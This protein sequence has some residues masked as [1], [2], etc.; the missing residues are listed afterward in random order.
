MTS[1]F[2]A[3]MSVNKH[4]TTEFGQIVLQ[5]RDDCGFWWNQIDQQGSEPDVLERGHGLATVIVADIDGA[6]PA[7]VVEKFSGSLR[8]PDFFDDDKAYWLTP[9]AVVS[10]D[11]NRVTEIEHVLALSERILWNAEGV[12]WKRIHPSHYGVEVTAFDGEP[13]D[14]HGSWGHITKAVKG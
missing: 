10:I 12:G 8:E 11:V 1:H 9:D 3:T 4:N 6:A 14:A 5:D 7:W 2:D 13:H